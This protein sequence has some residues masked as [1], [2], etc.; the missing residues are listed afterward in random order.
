[1]CRCIIYIIRV[2]CIMETRTT[3]IDN[4]RGGGEMESSIHVET[5]RSIRN[6]RYW[7]NKFQV[8]R[9]VGTLS[10]RLVLCTSV[11]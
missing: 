2:V 7:L 5:F 9:Y 3:L 6:N 1:M 11:K 4:E 10:T 8:L